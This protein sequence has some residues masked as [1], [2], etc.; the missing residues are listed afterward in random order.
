L[1]QYISAL[2]QTAEKRLVGHGAAV[3]A[4]AA[5][6][7]AAAAPRVFFNN[8]FEK[9]ARQQLRSLLY[10]YTIFSEIFF[11]KHFPI[12][13]SNAVASL[14]KPPVTRPPNNVHRACGDILQDDAGTVTLCRRACMRCDGG[15]INGYSPGTMQ[16][17][18]QH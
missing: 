9:K 6:C 3:L 2:R 12:G 10:P 16:Q 17:E 8:F 1:S 5:G 15:L 11:R 4:A 7:A 14:K 13:A 18:S